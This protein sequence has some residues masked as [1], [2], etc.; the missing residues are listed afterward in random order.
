MQM[1][2]FRTGWSPPYYCPSRLRSLNHSSSYSLRTLSCGHLWSSTCLPGWLS[3]FPSVSYYGFSWYR[4]LWSYFGCQMP[5]SYWFFVR[6]LLLSSVPK[7]CQFRCRGVPEN[8]VRCCGALCFW[9]SFRMNYNE[10]NIS[11][12][13]QHKQIIR[14]P[15]WVRLFSHRFPKCNGAL[16]S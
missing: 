9:M 11:E 8:A 1:G 14:T 12:Q 6:L 4:S 5:T 2:W 15:K 7:R 3:S 16:L 10:S 13:W